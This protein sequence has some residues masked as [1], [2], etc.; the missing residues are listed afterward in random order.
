MQSDAMILQV[1]L[2]SWCTIWTLIAICVYH[3]FLILCCTVCMV[4][5]CKTG[6]DECMVF[7][8][9][10]VLPLPKVKLNLTTK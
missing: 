10:F 4:C 9:S 2:P 6:V 1:S 5:S 8:S 3:L 7:Y